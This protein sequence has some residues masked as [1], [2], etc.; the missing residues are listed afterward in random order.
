MQLFH[1]EL[2]P[3]ALFPSHLP[4]LCGG[5]MA[6][7]ASGADFWF[8][9]ARETP[10]SLSSPPSHLPPPNPHLAELSGEQRGLKICEG[11]IV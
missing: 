9:F 4:S 8:S 10:L 1:L 3:L 11:V 7:M 6:G 5:V 2:T